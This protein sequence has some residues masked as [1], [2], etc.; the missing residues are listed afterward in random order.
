MPAP[1]WAGKRQYA[2]ALLTQTSFFVHSTHLRTSPEAI[3]SQISQGI[4][5]HGRIPC[6]IIL[7]QDPTAGII[8]RRAVA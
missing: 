2:E 4:H 3:W 1:N 5:P 7:R 6:E 8:H